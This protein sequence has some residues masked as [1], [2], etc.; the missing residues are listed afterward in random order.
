MKTRRILSAGAALAMTAGL[1]AGTFGGPANAAVEETHDPFGLIP[2][3]GQ[4]CRDA[5][6]AYA[7]AGWTVVTLTAMPDVY[8]GNADPE[9]I[10]AD[11]GNDDVSGASGV[12]ILCLEWGNDRGQGNAQNDFVYG[13]EGKDTLQ[14]NNGDD[15]LD[16]GPGVDSC[17]GGPG[18]DSFFSC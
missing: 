5:A 17:N 11:A 8:V 16:G 13:M 6:P 15:Y 14:G 10:I 3:S 9:F 12:D 18:V 7:M 4:D 1:M 2:D